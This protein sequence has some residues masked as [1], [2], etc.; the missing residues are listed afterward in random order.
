MQLPKLAIVQ[1]NPV[2]GDFEGNSLKILNAMHE[3]A[4]QGAELL[5]F[6]E[7]A[8]CGY[9]LGDLAYRKDFVGASEQALN[10]IT[11]ASADAKLSKLTTVI[12]S[13]TA[14]KMH[15]AELQRSFATA[16]NTALV[17]RDGEVIA[18]YHKQLLPNYDV[19]DDW[20]NF[21]PGT[22]PEFFDVAGKKCTLAICEDIWDTNSSL[23]VAIRAEQPSLIISPNGSPFTTDKSFIR[24]SAAQDFCPGSSLLYV[25]LRGGQDDL[26]FDGD[27][28]L[29]DASGQEVWRAAKS[30]SLQLV[31]PSSPAPTPLPQRSELSEIW[32]VLKIGL[33]DYIAKTGQSRVIL[34]LSGGIDSA[35]CAVLAVDALGKENVLGVRLPSRYSSEHSLQDAED[36]AKN[37]GIELRTVEIDK[38]HRTLESQV[39]LSPLAEENLQ[40]RLRAVILMAISNSE[41]YL[42]LSTGNKSEIAVG[43]STIYG[44]AAGGFAP[45]KDVYKTLVWRLATWRNLDNSPIPQNS[46]DKTPSAELRPGQSDQDSLPSYEIL[47][48]ILLQL[49]EGSAA[50]EEVVSQGHSEQLVEEIDGLVRR[51]EWKRSQGAIGTKI[52]SV[53]FGR[54]RRVPITTRFRRP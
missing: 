26:V 35:L 20:R 39:A 54:G 19:F 38:L 7:L 25:N 51:A 44:D 43:Y 45:I 14:A 10:K 34:G 31:Q 53:S 18:T 40:A 3:A 29:M 17:V 5:V 52:T 1:M 12:G 27:S 47:D 15:P 9:P 36:L 28:F 16:H 6:G 48:Q 4:E 46:I 33:A 37:L 50:I 32:D 2:V 41:G 30:N 11:Q 13:V 24:R 8:L 21:V 23:A 42:L 22:H 49:I